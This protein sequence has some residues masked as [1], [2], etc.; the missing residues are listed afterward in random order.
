MTYALM[1]LNGLTLVVLAVL[2]TA[3][4]VVPFSKYAEKMGVR[5]P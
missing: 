3:G 4:I 1:F 2:F 5:L